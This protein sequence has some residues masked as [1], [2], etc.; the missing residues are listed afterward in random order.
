MSDISNCIDEAMQHSADGLT[1]QELRRELRNRGYAHLTEAQIERMLRDSDRHVLVGRGRWQLRGYEPEPSGEPAQDFDNESIPPCTIHLL[2]QVLPAYVVFDIE[3]TGTRLG[4]DRVLQFAALK[5]VSGIPVAAM[6]TWVDPGSR[7][8]PFAVRQLLNISAGSDR[9]AQLKS[10]PQ[11]RDVVDQFRAFVGELPTVAHNGVSFDAPFLQALVSD[12]DYQPFDTLELCALALPDCESFSLEGLSDENATRECLASM[13]LDSDSRFHDALF[14][15]AATHLL[16][17]RSVRKLIEMEPASRSA[18]SFLLPELSS[19]VGEPTDADGLV[20]G[21]LPPPVSAPATLSAADFDPEATENAFRAFVEKSGR[22]IRPGQLAMVRYVADALFAPSFKMIESPTGTGKSLALAFPAALYST[23]TGTRVGITTRTKNLQNQLLRDLESVRSS[24]EID[25][26]YQ[27]IRGRENYACLT[28]LRDHAD[29]AAAE[30]DVMSR[31]CLAAVYSRLRASRDDPNQC[32]VLTPLEEGWLAHRFGTVFRLALSRIRSRSGVCGDGPCHDYGGCFP[33]YVIRQAM[34]ANVLV[35]NHSLWLMATTRL[36]EMQAILVDEAHNLEDAATEAATCEASRDILRDLMLELLSPDDRGL[37]PRLRAAGVT[38]AQPTIPQLLGLARATR[39]QLDVF[40]GE[41]ERFLSRCGVDLRGDYP[42]LF[43]V[44][45]DLRRQEPARWKIIGDALQQLIRVYLEPICRGLD[46]AAAAIRPRDQ[47]LSD[48]V[49]DLSARL[50]EQL[51]YLSKLG[52]PVGENAV[53]WIEFSRSDDGSARFWAVKEAPISVAETLQQFYDK[54]QSAVFTSA[55]LS[56]ERNDFTFFLNRLGLSDRIGESDRHALESDLPYHNALFMIPR[57]LENIPTPSRAEFFAAELARELTHLFSFTNGHGM[58]LMTARKRMEQVYE[59]AGPELEKSGVSL[60]AQGLSGSADAITSRLRAQPSGTAVVGLNKLWEGVDVPGPALSILGI[61]KLPFPAFHQPIIQ[62]RREAVVEA[63]GSDFFDYLL[64]W[65]LIRFKQGFGRLVRGPEDRGVV[66]LFD[67]RIHH[68]SY[69]PAVLGCLPGYCVRP[70]CEGSRI[71][72]LRAISEHLPELFV[73]RNV[74]ELLACLPEDPISAVAAL[75]SQWQLSSPVTES[76]YAELK[77]RVL[78]LIKA[79][80]G[81]DGF[82]SEEQEEIIKQI[83]CGRDVIGILPTGSGKSFAFQLPALLRKG[84]TVVVSPLIALMRDQI[85]KLHGWGIDIAEALFSGQS[86]DEREDAMRRI[87]DGHTRILY[88]SP[89]RLRDT[90]LQRC[91]AE[92]EVCQLVVDE[93]HC[94]SLWGASFRPDYLTIREALPSGDCRVAALTATA[95]PIIEQDIEARLKMEDPVVVRASADRP[96]LYLGVFNQHSLGW[97]VTRAT[98]K[99]HLLTA[100][101]KAAD[102]QRDSMIV[103]VATTVTAEE[104]AR[105]LAALGYD[106]RFYHGKMTAE[107]RADAQELFMEDVVNI[108]VATKAFGMGIDKPDIRYVVHYDMPGD[109]ESYFQEAGR[110]GRDG[111]DSYAVILFHER[112]IKTQEYFLQNA[113]VDPARLRMLADAIDPWLRREEP[114]IERELDLEGWE[115]FEVNLGLYCLQQI[116]YLVK[117]ADVPVSASVMTYVDHLRALSAADELPQHGE[118]ARAVLEH[119][120]LGA[121]QREAVDM[122]SLSKELRASLTEL[123]SAFE[124]LSAA[125]VLRYRP[126]ERGPILQPGPACD[127]SKIKLPPD[128]LDY[129]RRRRSKLMEMVSYSSSNN[130]CRRET[131]LRYL[132]ENYA[133]P[134]GNCD[135]CAPTK[136]LPWSSLRRRDVPNPAQFFDP[137]FVILQIVEENLARAERDGKPPYSRSTLKHILTGNEYMAVGNEPDP[138]RRSW[139]RR[140]VRSFPQW[141]LLSSLRSKDREIDESVDALVKDGIIESVEVDDN[142]FRYSYLRLTSAGL[143]ALETGKVK[144]S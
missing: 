8:I 143:R 93:A 26:S 140:R 55:T 74:E 89:E 32:G 43:R 5:V 59:T 128:V 39:Q 53:R 40:G 117:S 122:R 130:I 54:V 139:R 6:N 63:G 7:E 104:V 95:T 123:D 34:S 16:L 69:K 94:V 82:R 20:A 27:L 79:V 127:R 77:G 108:L 100:L 9:E 49:G 129:E 52:T 115:D 14:D 105:K 47:R 61:E 131:I 73:G 142:G 121:Y 3:T 44:K 31:F 42:V 120:H 70:E 60:L 113:L 88:A 56:T 35:L 111:R 22:A 109:L 144:V 107:E 118:L 12:F 101:A 85:D 78:E 103:Y 98:D 46:A 136:V 96:E 1:V 57:Y 65:T 36:P 119:L 66:I 80:F 91:L 68:K 138:Y 21:L 38:T 67:R 72:M 90:R 106:A 24:G 37:L 102:A 112:D 64:P 97:P 13:A 29:T 76:E 71:E 28:A 30:G 135:V 2:P 110:A 23:G 18:L 116:G 33:G 4:E 81:F 132:G 114:L 134:C 15:C 11:L 51:D 10:A 87:R 45:T 92:S 50:K 99:F 86:A 137:S 17:Q 84:L 25:F 58:G 126:W 124:A 48:E 62:A 75:L 83:L 141:G 41:L 125:D 19:L 133:G